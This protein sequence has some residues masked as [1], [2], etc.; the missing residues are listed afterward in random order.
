MHGNVSF[1]I[2]DGKMWFDSYDCAS[3]VLRAFEKMGDI[4]VKFNQ[5]VHLNYTRIHLYSEEPIYLGNA[6][7]IFGPGGNES[8]A[9]NITEFYKNFQ[10]HQKFLQLVEH[11]LDALYDVF[12]DHKFYFFYNFEY[13]YLPMKEPFIKLTYHEVPLPDNTLHWKH[14]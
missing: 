2:T 14:T 11:I 8:L 6:S 9:N 13:W 12:A 10:S 1:L 4:G 5:S 7:Q 3:F